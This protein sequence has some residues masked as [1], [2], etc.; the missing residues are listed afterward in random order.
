MSMTGQNVV[1]RVREI[2]NDQDEASRDWEDSDLLRWVNDGVKAICGLRNDALLASDGTLTTVTELT[3][4][5]GTISIPDK[6]RVPLTWY[7]VWMA[8]AS[9][10]GDKRD[11]AR[12]ADAKQAFTDLVRIA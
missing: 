5:S 9:E 11:A 3:A 2:L 7:I 1:D 6:F 12:A 10:A 8:F 4:L